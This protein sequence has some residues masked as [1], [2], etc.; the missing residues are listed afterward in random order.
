M[1]YVTD[2]ESRTVRKRPG[3]RP[4]WTASLFGNHQGRNN[5]GYPFKGQTGVLE[6]AVDSDVW[7]TFS[8][9]VDKGDEPRLFVRFFHQ[10]GTVR[11]DD[12]MVTPVGEQ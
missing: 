11:L 5:E 6:F 12:V 1:P 4:S 8:L 9:T 3:P 2:N 7:K 10:K